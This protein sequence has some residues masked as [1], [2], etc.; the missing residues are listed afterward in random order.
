VPSAYGAHLV[1]IDAR[2]AGMPPPFEDVRDRVR[3][4]WLGEDRR[5]RVVALLQDLARRHPVQVDSAA[6]RPRRTS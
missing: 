4:R 5:T 2:E 6:W 3:E 1:W